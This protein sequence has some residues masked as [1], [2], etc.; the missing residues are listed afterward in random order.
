[1]NNLNE[2]CRRFGLKSNIRKTE[3]M[4]LTK[5]AEQL[6]VNIRLRDTA[7]KQV[8]SFK[9]LGSI[10]HEDGKCDTDIKSRIGMSK[11]AFGQI[12][13]I[14]ISL[15]INVRTRIRVL[16]AYVWSVLL[17]G[18]EAWT[19]S[20]EMRKRLEAAEI[21]FYRRML[22][23]PWTARRSNEDVLRMAGTKRELL[24]VIRKRQLG[25]LGHILRGNGLEKDCLLG[26]VEGVRARGRQRT[27]Y[28]D[29]IKEIVGCGTI[30][31]VLRLAEDRSAWRAI[32]A[33]INVDTALR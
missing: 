13:K 7:M 4:G 18:C 24:S 31:G 17:F 32:V 12:R 28:L 30:D 25:F 33:N 11:A 29:G 20:K 14:L 6:P 10:I 5:R 8:S 16:K 22:R 23:V 1:M 2:S 27:K 9:Y 21:W 19:I 15:S 26:M 3:V